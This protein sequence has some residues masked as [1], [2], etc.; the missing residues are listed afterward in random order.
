MVPDKWMYCT[1][2]KQTVVQNDC[3]ICLH[4]QGKYEK[5]E[6][7][8]SWTNLVKGKRQAE[9]PHEVISDRRQEEG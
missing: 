6:Q 1:Q 3:G 2:C 7:P 5:H 9:P 8:D 4:C